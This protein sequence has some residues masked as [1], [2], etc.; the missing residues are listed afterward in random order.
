MI[1]REES[2]ELAIRR[3]DDFFASK[4]QKQF[5]GSSDVVG[6]L[7]ETPETW[8]FNQDVTPLGDFGLYFVFTSEVQKAPFVT[9]HPNI[10]I[11]NVPYDTTSADEIVGFYQYV[12][13]FA[14]PSDFERSVGYVLSIFTESASTFNLKVKMRCLGTDKGTITVQSI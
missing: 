1:H 14:V 3:I 8:D 10:L 13:G 12:A 6:Y 5:I 2:I 11:N 7:S 9:F 4:R